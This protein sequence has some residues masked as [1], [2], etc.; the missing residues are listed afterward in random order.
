MDNHHCFHQRINIRFFAIP[1][2]GKGMIWNAE[3]ND[4]K[5]CCQDWIPKNGL[6]PMDML[7]FG[8]G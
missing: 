3:K 8:F 5:V 6:K 1:N 4:F 2:F 7:F